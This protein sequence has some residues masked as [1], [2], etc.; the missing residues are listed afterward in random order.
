MRR[1]RGLESAP[2]GNVPDLIP[3]GYLGTFGQA[4]NVAANEAAQ[5]VYVTGSVVGLGVG[6][7]GGGE[8][9]GQPK[10][11][12][13]SVLYA[14]C[15]I[16]SFCELAFEAQDLRFYGKNWR[17]RDRWVLASPTLYPPLV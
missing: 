16:S 12:R 14:P 17:P 11:Y 13:F 9:R 7:C 6:V 3:D 1:L 5:R 2:P 15:K 8:C 4:R 10:G